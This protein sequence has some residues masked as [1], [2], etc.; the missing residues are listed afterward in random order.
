MSNT[1]PTPRFDAPRPGTPLSLMPS[2]GRSGS[3]S[4]TPEPSVYGGDDPFGDSRSQNPHIQFVEPSIGARSTSEFGVSSVTL[5]YDTEGKESHY[6]EEAERMPLTAGQEFAG[7]FYPPGL[8]EYRTS[9]L[10]KEA[11]NVPVM[12]TNWAFHTQGQLA[13]QLHRTRWAWRVH[14]AGARRSNAE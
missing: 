2:Q 5:P 14:G 9:I 1:P 12:W 8:V 7:G 6:D 3:L 13:V 11:N 10:V 4:S